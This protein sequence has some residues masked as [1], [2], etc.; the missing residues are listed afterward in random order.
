MIQLPLA[1]LIPFTINIV[2]T[3]CQRTT[4]HWNEIVHLSENAIAKKNWVPFGIS[5]LEILPLEVANRR[6]H[7]PLNPLVKFSLEFY[8]MKMELLDGAWSEKNFLSTPRLEILMDIKNICIFPILLPPFL[9]FNELIFTPNAKNLVFTFTRV[10][11]EGR[12]H[13]FFF[14]LPFK[15]RPNS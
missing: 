4:D 1:P 13:P 9:H 10:D 8:C 6:R 7:K 12:K 2:L 15:R 14:F 5:A 3:E 11:V